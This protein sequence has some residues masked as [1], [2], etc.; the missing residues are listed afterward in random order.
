MKK[1][2]NKTETLEIKCTTTNSPRKN[3]P[4]YKIETMQDIVNAVTVEN[5]EY[6]LKDFKAVLGAAL[7]TKAIIENSEE[8]KNLPEAEKK[9]T[10]PSYTWID[11]H[12]RPRAKSKKK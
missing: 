5:I 10:M 2:T 12:K 11:D 4:R 3:A 7:L 9:V 8:M 6:F 1:K